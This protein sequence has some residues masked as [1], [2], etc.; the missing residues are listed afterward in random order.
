MSIRQNWSE[1][2]DM[3]S[4]DSLVVGLDVGL[5]VGLGVGVGYV[6]IGLFCTYFI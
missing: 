2:F 3:Q 5:D 1:Q 6:I 4:F